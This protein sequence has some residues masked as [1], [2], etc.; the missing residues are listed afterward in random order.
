MDGHA[1]L[2]ILFLGWSSIP[3]V[4]SFPSFESFFE[5]YGRSYRQRLVEYNERKAIYL[6]RV[7]QFEMH[8]SNADRNWTAAVNKFWDW[9]SSELSVL[10]GWS[11]HG[12]KRDVGAL[13]AMSPHHSLAL[14]LNEEQL[15]EQKV[16]N[17]KSLISRKDQGSCGSC[18][19]VTAETI[20]NAHSE[21]YQGAAARTFS[22][23]EMVSCIPNPQE[24]GGQG[25]CRGATVE[26]ALDYVWKNGV[27]TDTQTPYQGVDGECTARQMDM[28]HRSDGSSK[29]LRSL[30]R[31]GTAG[32]KF[33][34]KGWRRLAENKY[35]PL[36][37]AV[38]TEGPVGV[39]ASADTWFAYGGGVFDYCTPDVVINH[40]V[41][42]IGYGKDAGKKYW[43]IQ[44]S[45]G[46][47][48]GE[49]GRIRLLR[50]NE[51]E[52]RCGWDSKPEDGTGCK[53]GPPRVKVCGMCG[54]LY[55][56]ALPMFSK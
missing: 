40:A 6:Q 13:S 38:A 34:M 37:Q 29:F 5:L 25:G 11:G 51:H 48:W 39:S 21:I 46:A 19:A 55:D 43:L 22:T 20:L 10:Q 9:T 31:T 32:L 42:L 2:C 4:A 23:Q 49:S 45:W 14:A 30:R 52:V 18:W 27:A 15:P 36:L 53:G 47:G 24:C 3:V 26:M 35:E 56:S 33:G 12:M 16:W 8:N 54:I 28:S 17:L 41:S 1:L 7:A 44:N 50:Q